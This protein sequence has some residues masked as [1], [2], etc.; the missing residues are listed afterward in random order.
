VEL[1]DLA[2]GLAH[3]LKSSLTV[4]SFSV[5]PQRRSRTNRQPAA[6]FVAARLGGL[7]RLN[8]IVL[9]SHLRRSIDGSISSFVFCYYDFAREFAPIGRHEFTQRNGDIFM[10]FVLQLNE[11][12]TKSE[13]IT[14]SFL[15]SGLDTVRRAGRGSR[16]W[17]ILRLEPPLSLSSAFGSG[18][19]NDES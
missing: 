14:L 11:R 18:P 13:F 3:P 6:R 2:D 17:L 10:Y 9:R 4:D 19:S 7:L 5:L 8:G 16:A 12:V 1:G 15:L